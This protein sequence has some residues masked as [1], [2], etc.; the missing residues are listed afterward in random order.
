MHLLHKLI[1]IS[2][3]ESLNKENID[4]NFEINKFK[5]YSEKTINLKNKIEEEINK[6]NA[7]Y[8]KIMTNITKSF[9]RKHEELLEQENNLKDS[10]NNETT[11]IKEKLEK[12]LTDINESIRN[13]E[14]IK[15]G[16]NKLKN[17][18]NNTIKII[19]YISTINKYIKN[20]KK[21]FSQLMKN[22]NIIYEEDN[23]KIKYDEYFFNGIYIPNN[24]EFKDIN[25]SSIN[26]KWKIDDI[27]II[28]IDKN[29]IKYILE[30]RKEKDKFKKI[31]EGNSNSY[32][33]N[34]LDFK[35][36][37]EFR[38]CC[39]YNDLIGPWTQVQS[40][41]LSKLNNLV[42][43]NDLKPKQFKKFV[44]DN[45][46]PLND[47]YILILKDGV[48][49]G[50]YIHYE[51]GKYLIIYNGDGLLNGDYDCVDTNYTFPI[52]ILEKSQSKIIY[53]VDISQKSTSGVE[54]R[55]FNKKNDFVLIKSIEVFKYN[56]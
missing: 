29:N 24:I 54:F 23:F 5:E 42:L 19:T 32:I 12:F 45:H 13:S 53:Q 48:Q 10:L 8:D 46:S 11:K 33:I 1:T 35:T 26:I 55:V 38:I 39:F 50:P 47:E 14:K 17:E 16:V 40:F 20:M 36:D 49:Y 6:L 3:I 44:H 30:L 25:I 9:K 18:E 21:L 7:V 22:S 41:N 15:K 28:D 56:N 27:N 34:N 31:Y 4:I 43:K 51:L 37:Y 52:K 2:D